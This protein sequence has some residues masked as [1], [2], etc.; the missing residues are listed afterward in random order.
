MIAGV[1]RPFGNPPAFL[2]PMRS[3]RFRF[4][5]LP[6]H[7]AES[8]VCV[9][10]VLSL[11]FLAASANA[12]KLPRCSEGAGAVEAAGRDLD[13][14]RIYEALANLKQ[15]IRRQ[16]DCA[17]AYFYLGITYVGIRQ[18]K[19]A[20]PYA[21]K[22][23]ELDPRNG[24][25]HNLLG[26]ILLEERN[27]KDALKELYQA[28]AD[29]R[30]KQP[31]KVW[32]NIGYAREQLLQWDDAIGAFNAALKIRH[33]DVQ[34][35]IALAK[36]Y[37]ERNRLSDGIR[38]LLSA[39]RLAPDNA[40]IYALLGLAYRRDS[41]TAQQV[42][43]ESK[44]VSLNPGD[45]MAHYTLAQGLM[46]LGQKERGLQELERFR[47]LEKQDLEA[48]QRAS[49]LDSM[50]LTATAKVSQGELP[51]AAELLQ[52]IVDADSDFVPAFYSLGFVSL[53][54][55][56]YE[57]AVATLE[58][59]VALDPVNAGAYFY[60][61][62]AY[63]NTGKLSQALEATR[64]ALV[65]YDE[66][67]SYFNQLGEIYLELGRESDAEDAFEQAVTLDRTF[68][69]AQLNLG[70]LAL[71]LGEMEKAITHLNAAV[72]IH[73]E[74][75]EPHRLLGL[76]YFNDGRFDQCIAQYREAVRIKPDDEQLRM[77]LAEA[78]V[79]L[80]RWQDAEQILKDAIQA[81]THSQRAH[82]N[83]GE[84]YRVQG[85]FGEALGEFQKA[86]ATGTDIGLDR[87]YAK[88]GI[89]YSN[90]LDVD[91][92]TRSFARA[93]Q[94]NPNLVVARLGLAGLYARQS[95]YDDALKEYSTILSL[96]PNRPDV[97][98]NLAQIYL[99]TSTF[100]RAIEAGRKAL[101]LDPRQR[102]AEYTLAQALIRVGLVDQGHTELTKFQ[103]ME[104]EAEAEEHHVRE[105]LSLNQEALS[106]VQKHQ[107][108]K[109]I[110]LLRRAIEHDSGMGLSYVR[111]GFVLMKKGDHEQAI[112]NLRKALEL[113]FDLPQIHRYL[114]EE[115]KAM[116]R[117]EDSAKEHSTYTKMQEERMRVQSEKR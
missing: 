60:L 50:F 71:Q 109:A 52:Q 6:R 105:A 8:Y 95:R 94:I 39:A 106:A 51:Q 78:L 25:Y 40:E 35:Q 55:A 86:A 59:T 4:D 117:L 49:R 92:A 101:E 14:G 58:K 53:K 70:S 69:I 65:I 74:S 82:Y 56:N 114:A 19:I 84:L 18:Y 32:T 17:D 31:E 90:Q 20:T 5:G 7:A 10:I 29:K 103:H 11:I 41:Q 38:E 108:D 67:A 88:A 33:D 63:K 64:R 62:N 24:A 28:L 107:Y 100:D 22:A 80:K 48:Q 43:A 113:N 98:A 3:C 73:G 1:S 97:Y 79:W 102:Q 116:G 91:N 81:N 72:E 42:E 68:A 46:Q 23:I 9:L 13:S 111:L 99:R 93:L 15:V 26:A 66:N 27:S 37:L 30:I 16:P 47:D 77:N 76:A 89:V 34:V 87:I 21:R 96:E 115:Y 12:A 110:T 36:A 54:Q 45:K 2:F 83:L 104:A 61:G 44:A 57:S 112:T 75:A 85:R